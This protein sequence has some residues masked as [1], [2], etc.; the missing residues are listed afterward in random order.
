MTAGTCTILGIPVE[1]GARRVGCAL[2]PDA[3]RAA[4]LA[5]S[6]KAQG[7]QIEDLGNMVCQDQPGPAVSDP[8]RRDWPLVVAWI[9][10]IT[11]Q[12]R[13]GV[14]NW[15]LLILGGDHVIAAGT[16]P[17]LAQHCQ[18][19]GQPMF[20]LWLDAHPDMHTLETTRSGNLHGVP[21]GYALGQPGFDGF[22]PKL[23]TPLL[24]ENVLMLGTRSIDPE[25]QQALAQSHITVI[26]SVGLRT[27]GPTAALSAF[28]QKV[29]AANG[30]LHVSLDVD[31]LDPTLAPAVGTPVADGA[32]LQQVR[33]IT[34]VL[35]ASGL[36]RSLEV[37]ELNPL[38]DPGGE[39]TRLVLETIGQ[40]LHP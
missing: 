15:P 31:F 2:A 9:K 25:E 36:V 33:E 17:G 32:N 38:L 40:I 10:T 14:G 5:A 24:P 11:A 37:A 13:R 19:A 28:L 27:Q 18:Q 23:A 39:T 35:Q 7:Y 26:D 30:H 3:L 20:V 8:Y 22:F 34:Q 6:L 1:I 4:G 21:M 29:R 16:L 12:I